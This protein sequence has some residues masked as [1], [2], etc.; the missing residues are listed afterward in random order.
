VNFPQ[1]QDCR[2]DRQ[3]S[4]MQGVKTAGG[5][6]MLAEMLKEQKEVW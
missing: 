6:K 1:T 4:I 3:K 5:V 2:L